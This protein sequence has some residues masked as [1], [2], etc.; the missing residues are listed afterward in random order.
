MTP[1]SIFILNRAEFHLQR[2]SFGAACR[3][4]TFLQPYSLPC[5]N[6]ASVKLLLGDVILLVNKLGDSLSRPQHTG[7]KGNRFVLLLSEGELA[8]F[9]KHLRPIPKK[10]IC[11]NKRAHLL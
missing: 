9:E 2:C 8:L 1:K 3:A 6:Q 10:N 5:C 11:S 4:V 7:R